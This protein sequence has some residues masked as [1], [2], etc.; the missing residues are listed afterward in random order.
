MV[1]TLNNQK[2]SSLIEVLV[3]IA[4]LGMIAAAFLGEICTSYKV[5]SL[6]DERATAESLARSQ[7]EY[8]KDQDY[9]DSGIY[10]EISTPDDYDFG[11][12]TA[13]EITGRGPDMQKITVTVEHKG[14][15]LILLE[16][17]KL[18]R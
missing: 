12:M 18:D 5:L 16:G 13:E 3:G 15:Q 6:A 14:N 7:L 9:Q 17:Y 11:S 8:V 1:G 2:G 10:Q 4:L